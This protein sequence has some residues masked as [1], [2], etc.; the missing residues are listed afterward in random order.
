MPEVPQIYV[1]LTDGG[2]LDW[3]VTRGEIDVVSVD[4]DE[5]MERSIEDWE[6]VIGEL[7]RL[8]PSKMRDR[9]IANAQEEIEKLRLY[10]EGEAMAERQR[11]TQRVEDARKVLREAGEL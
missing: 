1:Y 4:W 5:N 3:E 6:D 9:E 10:E 7:E 11:Q 2:I 8:E